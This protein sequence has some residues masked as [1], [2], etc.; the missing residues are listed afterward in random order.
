MKPMLATRGD[1][2]PTGPGWLH[3]VKWDG[4]RA[5]VDVSDGRV[6]VTSRNENDVSAAYPELAALGD[7][8]R[9]RDLLLDGEIVALGSGAPSFRDLA[10]RMHVR[11][12]VK[13]ARLARHNPVTLIAFDL[14]R[15]DGADLCARPLSERRAALL[16]LGLDDAAWQV[17]PTYDDGAVLLDAAEAQGLEGIVSK[18]L[19]SRYHP[20]RRSKDWLK[21]PIRPTG[22]YVVGGYRYET[23]SDARLGAVLVG[24]PD[25]DRLVFRGR[26]GSGIA[27][28]AG[29]R[30]GELL[31]PLVRGSS[32]FADELPRPDREGTVW[33]EPTVVVDVQYL[34]LTPDGRLRQ[35]AYRGIRAD[36]GPDDVEES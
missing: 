8:A 26:V 23:G 12:A 29:Q 34:N 11:D 13:A 21:F 7:W 16:D 10:D 31:R 30:L 19:S 4:I 9:S 27:G 25:G 3:E 28:K 5:L 1:H 20:D 17:P 15:L 36:L 22:S 2:V 24:V 18:K 6:V 33:V 32:P 14:L 35:P